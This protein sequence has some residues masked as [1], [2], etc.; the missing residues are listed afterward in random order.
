MKNIIKIDISTYFIILLYLI[1]GNYK[2]VLILYFIIIIH[3]L[4]HLFFIKLFNKK[5]IEIKI[6]PFGGITKYNSL[7]NH[8]IKQE[9]LIALSG[10]FNQII[11]ILIYNLLFK[12]NI[13]NLYTY[14]I[15]NRLN[16]S[17][18]IFNLLPII[19]LDGEKII[20]LILELFIPYV[21][22]NNIS[23]IIS[24]ISLLLLIINSISLKINIIF[25]LSFLLYK[26]IYFIK[27]KK[28]IEN[29]FFLERYIY[30]IPYRKIIYYNDY[31]INNMY[32][33]KYHFFNYVNEKKYLGTK[34]RNCKYNML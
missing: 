16:I 4:G 22:A 34:Y 26:L 30:D 10:V 9:L 1:S 19:G 21:K 25:V 24:L 18:L 17:L 23:I 8:N 12:I 7:V 27:N 28:Y 20:H 11:I 32:Q 15:F 33:E 29:K 13:I 2:E 3:E 14:N 6:Y 5:I 31:N